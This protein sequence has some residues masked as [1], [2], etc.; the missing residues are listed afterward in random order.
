MKIAVIGY[1]HAG[2][3][4]VASELS[5]RLKLP[6]FE[7]DALLEEMY[8]RRYHVRLNCRTIFQTHGEKFFRDLEFTVLK[9]T[10][11]KEKRGIF[12]LGGGSA[13][14]AHQSGLFQGVF[15]L[16][17]QQAKQVIWRRLFKAGLPAF[18]PKH[19]AELFFSRDVYKKTKSYSLI[20]D[21]IIH[22][23]S[24]AKTSRK[25]RAWVMRKNKGNLK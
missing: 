12:S 3:T 24:C 14:R 21:K 6:C 15:V 11:K 25:V 4:Q 23:Q 7:L 10:L 1:K 18:F 20:A 22:H 17:L 5:T 19:Y 9:R 13:L 2:K 16:Q 8:F